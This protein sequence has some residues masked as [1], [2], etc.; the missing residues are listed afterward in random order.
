MTL[1]LRELVLVDLGEVGLI[2]GLLH[3]TF[4]FWQNETLFV[5]QT[6]YHVLVECDFVLIHFNAG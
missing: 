5:I 2:D 1:F 3:K 4:L 6:G